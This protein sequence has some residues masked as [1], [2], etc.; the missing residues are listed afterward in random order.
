MSR[1]N[2]LVVDDDEVFVK[3]LTLKLNAE[4]YDV[5]TAADGGEAISAARQQKPDVILLDIG[6]PADMSSGLTDGFSIMQ[7]LKRVDQAAN[8]PV[9]FITGGDPANEYESKAK[10]IGAAGFLRKPIDHQQLFAVIRKIVGED[11]APA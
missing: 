9:I 6:F 4:G 7:W 3:T 5:L 2:I 1:K 8:I 11:S 10:A